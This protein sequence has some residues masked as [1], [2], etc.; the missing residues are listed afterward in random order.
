MGWPYQQ[1]PP[2]GWPLDY[3]SGLVPE[4]GFWLMN[5]D[6]YGNTVQDLSGNGNIG[7]ITTPSWRAGKFGSCLYFDAS[8]T[9]VVCGMNPILETLP[10]FT[11]S[12]WIY[13]MGFPE[14][15]IGSIIDKQEIR[16]YW[17]RTGFGE[18]L[19]GEV[20][21]G[22]TP[23]LSRSYD[24]GDAFMTNSWHHVAMTFSETDKTI[25][26][27]L[28]GIESPTYITQTSGVGTRTSDSARN[29]YIG[30][31][32][33]TESRCFNGLIDIPMVHNRVL[34]ASEIAQLNQ[35]PFWMFKD[36]AEVALMGGYQA[37]VEGIV[38]LRRRMEGY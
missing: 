15:N 23:A 19:T 32:S 29:L 4:A 8:T 34:S 27:F 11:Y 25:R 7:I 14:E 1:K 16:F 31:R 24:I 6:S 10:H 12:A 30:D 28:D 38:I 22:T 2:L 9:K 17:N 3:D 13:V 33:E 5:E 26:L 37:V 21:Y 20:L 18:H 35:F 36:P